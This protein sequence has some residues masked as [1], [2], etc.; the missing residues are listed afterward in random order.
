MP[1]DNRK[2]YLDNKL[3]ESLAQ[4]V[5]L[6]KNLRKEIFNML[7][8]E[9]LEIKIGLEA[10]FSTWSLTGYL[11]LDIWDISKEHNNRNIFL[12]E[13][14]IKKAWDDYVMIHSDLV[15]NIISDIRSIYEPYDCISYFETSKE[16]KEKKIENVLKKYWLTKDQL[17]WE[18]FSW[19]KY[20]GIRDIDLSKE[21]ECVDETIAIAKKGIWY[22][23]NKFKT[24]ELVSNNKDILHYGIQLH[25]SITSKDS[26]YIDD[27]INWIIE[28]LRD[29]IVYERNEDLMELVWKYL[30]DKILSIDFD[31]DKNATKKYIQKHI[32]ISQPKKDFLIFWI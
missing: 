6:P 32:T 23:N 19:I 30:L 28:H 14:S 15:D 2:T 18:V 7:E 4:K 11:T 25:K 20:W 21:S 10:N 3:F 26:H 27:R 5:G 22:L 16:E 17:S 1:K 9:V 12:T 13:E 31:E 29:I 24:I 8:W